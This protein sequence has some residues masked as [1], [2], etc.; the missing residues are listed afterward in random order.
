MSNP[1]Y[2][3]EEEA[4]EAIVRILCESIA[5]LGETIVAFEQAHKRLRER[6]AEL[7]AKYPESENNE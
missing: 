7:R 3:G 1:F 4:A 6:M 5:S 2:N